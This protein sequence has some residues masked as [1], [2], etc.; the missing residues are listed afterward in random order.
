MYVIQLTQHN[1]KYPAGYFVSKNIGKTGA[2]YTKL[3]Q[4]AQI[5]FTRESAI[6]NYCKGN[7]R[8]IDVASLMCG[9]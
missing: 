6:N 9:Q 3:L 8:V 1:G 4:H 5:Y 7:E 2:S